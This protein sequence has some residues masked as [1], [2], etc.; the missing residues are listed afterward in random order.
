MTLNELTYQGSKR[1]FMEVLKP[2]IENNL[3]E[4]MTYI[5]PFG[6]G[7]NSFTPIQTSSKIAG[8][9]NEPALATMNEIY[10]LTHNDIQKMVMETVNRL[11][12]EL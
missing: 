5:E 1:R 3:D 10:K 8:D 11:L 4:G 9:N 6:G 2:L 12:K 7:M